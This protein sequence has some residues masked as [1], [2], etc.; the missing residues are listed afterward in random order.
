MTAS[1]AKRNGS[2]KQQI[3]DVARQLF[4]ELSYRG[5]SMS[6]I[7]A[8]LGITKAALYYHF[9]GKR[10][11]YLDVL[12]ETFAEL[13][14]R[15][16]HAQSA[17]VSAQQLL[18]MI[19]AYLEFGVREHNLLNVLAARLA[20]ADTDLREFVAAFRAEVA[21]IFRPIVANVFVSDESHPR[22]D[23]KLTASMLT[24]MM[25]GLVLEHSFFGS[26]LDPA[27]V[28]TQIVTILGLNHE[29]IHP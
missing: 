20:P 2:S 16:E 1:G 13:L 8:R 26:N 7:S 15:L 3:V 6:D 12:R 5:V 9:A 22:V 21:G 28:A 4:S 11:L 27:T 19:T 17:D 29:P 18:Q 23:V 24:A 10:E 25:D 14:E